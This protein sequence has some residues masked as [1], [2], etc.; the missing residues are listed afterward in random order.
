MSLTRHIALAAWMTMEGLW[1]LL[2]LSFIGCFQIAIIATWVDAYCETY[3]LTSWDS[4]NQVSAVLFHELEH[5]FNDGILP[6]KLAQQMV[7]YAHRLNCVNL[8]Y[9]KENTIALTVRYVMRYIES[10]MQLRTYPIFQIGPLVLRSEPTQPGTL[11]DTVK[12]GLARLSES[13]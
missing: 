7:A 8:N 12:G 10:Q 5:N 9:S 3:T 1:P 2:C 6:E 11:T 13:F 4:R